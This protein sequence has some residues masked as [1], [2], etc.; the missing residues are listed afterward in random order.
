MCEAAGAHP[1]ERRPRRAQDGHAEVQRGRASGQQQDEPGHFSETEN[2]DIY[3]N[4]MQEGGRHVTETPE[5]Q[6]CGSS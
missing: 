6:L 5:A 3:E 4:K 2:R 1:A